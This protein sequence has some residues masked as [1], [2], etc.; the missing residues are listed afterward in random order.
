MENNHWLLKDK[1]ILVTGSSRGIG[2]YTALELAE[3]GAHV[4]ITS[5]SQAHCE[6]AVSKISKKH[7]RGSAAYYV[8][9]L[10]L[11]S[12]IRELAQKIK[13]DYDHLEILI[14]N[15]GGWF[16]QYQESEDDIEKTFA[17]N[18]L[19]YFMVAGLLMDLIEKSKP[20]RIINVA[21][22]AHKGVRR[23]R[24]GDIGFQKVYVPF[25]SY[26]QSKLANIM[27]TYELAD[28]LKGTGITVNTLHPGSIHSNFYRNSVLFKPIINLW[29]KIFGITSEE[30][31]KA[32]I[33]LAT[34][35]DVIN[36]T[37]RYF[38]DKKQGKS[39]KASYRQK[40]WKRL[41]KLSE[42]MSGFEYP[43]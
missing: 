16:S 30:G 35:E 29:M 18:H 25:F 42:E 11:Q 17:L 19:S 20:A 7:G 4:I 10:S 15:V 26:A 33:Y 32:S 12:E 37:G 22:G 6:E 36:I 5:R 13:K 8:A 14:N 39:S 27:F 24:F 41:W 2:F 38:L 9:D 1:N 31:A 43:I 23:I 28:R 3:K 21:S 34:S 40:D